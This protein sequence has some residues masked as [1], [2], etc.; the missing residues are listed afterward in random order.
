MAEG[1]LKQL[2]EIES[3]EDIVVESAGT[4][5]PSGVSPTNFAVL[6][7]VEMGIDISSH[8][9]RPLT[10]ELVKEVDLILV[11][12]WAHQ[13]FIEHFLSSARDKVFLVKTFGKERVEGNI[14]IDDPIGGDLDFYRMCGQILK[15]E[16]ERILPL[17]LRMAGHPDR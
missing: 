6:T 5:A 14:E 10:E 16:I 1:I 17:I 4:M 3:I 2:L 9:A 8:Q 7:M 13:H 12:E 11:M 15:Q